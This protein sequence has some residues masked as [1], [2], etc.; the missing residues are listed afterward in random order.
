MGCRTSLLHRHFRRFRRFEAGLR[1][2]FAG[3]SESPAGNGAVRV[4]PSIR[5]FESGTCAACVCRLCDIG[6][7]PICV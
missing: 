4:F 1:G 7:N 2:V 3:V 6:R 5:R